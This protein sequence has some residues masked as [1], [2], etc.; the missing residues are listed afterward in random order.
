MAQSGTVKCWKRGRS[1][2]SLRDRR[3][4]LVAGPWWLAE[5]FLRRLR[6]ALS[7][8]AFVILPSSFCLHHSSLFISSVG[9]FDFRLHTSCQLFNLL[10]LLERVGGQQTL[11]GFVHG[12]LQFSG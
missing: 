5:T 7:E 9:L 2:H 12:F 6:C 4:S 11:T 3:Y 10:G 1:R 8:A